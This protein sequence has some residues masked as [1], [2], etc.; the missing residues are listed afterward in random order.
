MIS[1]EGEAMS[2]K[3]SKKIAPPKKQRVPIWLLLII[4]A[5][6]ALIVVALI[7]SG[8]SQSASPV[9]PQVSGAPALQVDREKI[10]LGEVPLGQTVNVSFE[11]TNIG[12]QP[13]RFKERPYVEVIEGC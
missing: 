9:S 1:Q 7:G 6:G 2:T 13:L 11:L 8:S 3:A 10:D 12:D 4:I 5:G